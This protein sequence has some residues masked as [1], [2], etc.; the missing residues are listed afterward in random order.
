MADTSPNGV[1][2]VGWFS[3][4]QAALTSWTLTPRDDPV[5]SG[6]SGGLCDQHM[7]RSGR[8]TDAARV[9]ADPG[10]LRSA[11][12]AACHKISAVPEFPHGQ[13]SLF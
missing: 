4:S 7:G 9:D 3:H 10:R 8:Q 1:K 13:E 5:R 6:L 11:N 2:K 12:L